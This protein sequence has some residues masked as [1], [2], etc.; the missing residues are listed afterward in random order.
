MFAFTGIIFSVSTVTV[1]SEESKSSSRTDGW[2]RADSAHVG[3]M[4]AL[5]SRRD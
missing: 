3:V 5:T 4:E 2:L 1:R